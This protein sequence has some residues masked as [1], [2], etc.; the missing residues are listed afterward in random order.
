MT[1]ADSARENAIAIEAKKDGLRQRQTGEWTI[2]FVIADMP[3]QLAT[4]PMGT[5]YQVAL[6]EINGDETPV[7]HKSL[8]R[9]KWRALGPVR[10]AGVRCKEPKFWAYL[11]EELHFP[12]VVN[13]QMAAEAVRWQCQ[14]QSRSDMAK[15]GLSEARQRWYKIDNGFQAWD[16][17]EKSH[18]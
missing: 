12:K 9:D 4:A 13:E 11:T 15:P 5:R 1:E 16:A 6:V 8:D 3:Q 18:G 2:S 17:R 10:Q 7:D 14:V